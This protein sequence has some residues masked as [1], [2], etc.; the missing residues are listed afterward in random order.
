MNDIMMT[1]RPLPFRPAPIASLFNSL[2]QNVY[3]HS[4]G[5]GSKRCRIIFEMFPE[6]AKIP[7]IS[8]AS[9]PDIGHAPSVQRFQKLLQPRIKAATSFIILHYILFSKNNNL[10]S[11]L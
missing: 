10:K 6:R 8:P 5:H 1:C 2:Q 9:D 7:E 4:S 3:W 11:C